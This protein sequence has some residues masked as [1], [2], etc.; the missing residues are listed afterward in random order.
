LVKYIDKENLQK[1]FEE[2]TLGWPKSLYLMYRIC[3]A[4]IEYSYF[5][6]G[7]QPLPS[8]YSQSYSRGRE[9]RSVGASGRN[10]NR[11]G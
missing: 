10:S 4:I 7:I 5:L 9:S 6:Y 1:I 2:E 11:H 3:K 8:G